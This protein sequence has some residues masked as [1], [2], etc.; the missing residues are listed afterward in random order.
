MPNVNPNPGDFACVQTDTIATTPIEIGEWLSGGGAS[1]FDH[2]V[3]CSRIAEDGTVMIVEAIPSGAVEVPWHYED[4]QHL[5]STGLVTTSPAAGQ[6][7]LQYVGWGYN[8]A[9]YFAI[10][11]HRFHLP[12][13]PD[14]EKRI[15]RLHRVI[16]SQLVDLAEQDAGIHLFTD[17]RPPGYVRPSDLANLILTSLYTGDSK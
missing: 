16:C 14:L 1:E 9:D 3:I 15:A 5:W 10:A 13:A 17:G 6:A 8:W 11:A 12:F 4:H 7:A 2:S